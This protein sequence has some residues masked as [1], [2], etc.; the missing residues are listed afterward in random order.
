MTRPFCHLKMFLITEKFF[1][2]KAM[3]TRCP[4][5]YLIKGE[6]FKNDPIM[7]SSTISVRKNYECDIMA[8]SLASSFT[9]RMISPMLKMNVFTKHTNC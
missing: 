9:L 8:R 3:Y 7:D 2:N 5:E 4:P 1:F 6:L